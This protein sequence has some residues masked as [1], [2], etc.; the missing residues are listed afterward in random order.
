M[1]TAKPKKPPAVS[2]RWLISVGRI[3]ALIVLVAL[4]LGGYMVYRYETRPFHD[5]NHVSR[6]QRAME[7]IEYGVE[8]F[9]YRNGLPDRA[10]ALA[11]LGREQPLWE[12]IL[13][14][15]DLLYYTPRCPSMGRRWSGDPARNYTLNVTGPRVVCNARFCGCTLYWNVPPGG[16]D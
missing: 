5:T 6:C 12:P 2:R 7:R 13:A 8:D 4:P 14:N 1:S 9:Q 15:S 10:S 11:V 3:T 16:E